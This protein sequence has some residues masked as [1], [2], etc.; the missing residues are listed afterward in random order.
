VPSRVNAPCFTS[1]ECTHLLGENLRKK[2]GVKMMLGLGPKK[3]DTSLGQEGEDDDATFQKRGGGSAPAI[4]NGSSPL[5][6]NRKIVECERVWPITGSPVGPNGGG[7][8]RRLG[9]EKR[10]KPDAKE[11]KPPSPDSSGRSLQKRKAFSFEDSD[12]FSEP[13]TVSGRSHRL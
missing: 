1:S 4:G 12:N 7:N 13:L 9:V 3:I 5:H 10:N 8:L 2:L 6:H 11:S